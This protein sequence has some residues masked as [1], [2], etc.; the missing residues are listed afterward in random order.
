[1][2]AYWQAHCNCIYL[3]RRYVEDYTYDDEDDDKPEEAKKEETV[4]D[5][6]IGRSAAAIR[7]RADDFAQAAQANRVFPCPYAFLRKAAERPSA[8]EATGASGPFSHGSAPKDRVDRL[9]KV[10]LWR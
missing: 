10:R 3:Q 4:A 1:M 2:L 7:K 9:R 5:D 8:A 6:W